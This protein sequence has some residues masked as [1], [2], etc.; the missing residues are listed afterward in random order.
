MIRSADLSA[1]TTAEAIPPR[2]RVSAMTPRGRSRGG[3]SLHQAAVVICSY[4]EARWDLLVRSAQS[5]YRQ[6]LK[7][8]EI[9]V[10]VDHCPTLLRRAQQQLRAEAG[11]DSEQRLTIIANQGQRGLSD[12]RNTG[13]RSARLS[14]VAFLDDDAVADPSWLSLLCE[15]YQDPA[16]VGVGG[17]VTPRW[18]SARPVW[19][20]P[21]FDWVVGCSY[22]GMPEKTGAV[23]NLVGANM[24]FRRAALLRVGGFRQ[25]LGRVGSTP[26]G[27][28]ETE[29]C[30]RL[31]DRGDRHDQPV[32]VYEPAALV[33]H[34]V[35]ASRTTWRY[36]RSRCYSEGLSKARVSAVVGF[37]R[38]LSCER[39][40]LRRAVPRGIGAALAGAVRDRRSRAAAAAAMVAG[41]L[42]TMAGYAVGR[43]RQIRRDPL[44][45]LVTAARVGAL[46]LAVLLW[47]F[48]L[49]RVDL[50]QMTDVGLVSVLPVVYWIALG[51]LTISF[52]MSVLRPWPS[53]GLLAGH[54]IALIAI[55]HATPAIL[56]GTLRYAWAWKHVGIVDLILRH[57]SLGPK[58]PSAL[59]AYQ[60]WPGFFAGNALL[61]K[62]AGFHS[63]LSYASWGPPFF[64]LLL[65]GPLLLIFRRYTPDPRL[66]WTA[67]WFFYLGNWV[68]QD[69]FSPQA[70]CFFLYLVIIAVCLRWHSSSGTVRSPD[71]SSSVPV[72]A[73]R[74]QPI[75]RAT[76]LL[77]L[78]A[79][80]AAI[81]TSHQLTPFVLIA[82]TT[83][84]VVCRR[85]TE[86][87]LPLVVAG[88]AAGWIVLGARSFL[89]SNMNSIVGSFGQPEANTS[90]NLINL[91]HASS[92]QVLVAQF[93]RLLSAGIW[94][95]AAIG[96]WRRRKA[97]R[98][99]LPLILLAVAPLPLVVANNYGGEMV[100]RV[101]LFALPFV[102]FFAASSLFPS[103]A[104][105]RTR[106]TSIGLAGLSGVMLIAFLFSYYGKEQVNYFSSG[107]VAASAWLYSHAPA[108]SFIVGP[109][110]DLPWGY[111]DVQ[112][113]STYWFA[114]DTPA[115]RLHV[116]EDP[117]EALS[118]DL[119]S[120][121]YPA[122]YLI[123][124]R[125][126]TAEVDTT[127]L[128]PEGSMSQIKQAVLHSGR[129]QVVFR[130]ADATILVPA[131]AKARP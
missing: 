128:M 23:R 25:D 4:T 96:V 109:S 73:L 38:S 104:A 119:T 98:G 32:L 2:E 103:P 72:R 90:S 67:V 64:N 63:A 15:H 102:A 41:V 16:I 70:L 35:P 11:I 74:R 78:I 86:R 46:P 83:A 62:L 26:T 20:P 120:E 27:C 7:P 75:Q 12:A 66:M 30:I 95:L 58:L 87:V 115:G 85:C 57:G 37:D 34:H 81:A 42:A 44:A 124:S 28:E 127:G 50:A 106:F 33:H 19:F 80:A 51:V 112:L 9:V 47:C 89:A 123:F 8:G 69:Y 76:I 88:L 129:F 49:G 113:Y 39:A 110:G 94:V 68:G 126:Q 36:F 108:G 125:A 93:D 107:E 97:R 59:A 71:P 56:Y 91:S 114:L 24:S 121:R 53:P 105:G 6:T 118:A 10:V 40:Y 65:L 77:A 1:V 84:L 52:V 5:A 82:A 116:L 3:S 79:M 13:T 111:K 60:S 14:L 31:G 18:E 130:N 117:V 17:R 55:L 21:E 22:R 92:G 100:F 29:L 43:L 99:D 122:D 131:D 54:V 45:S 101:Y 61:I 48:S